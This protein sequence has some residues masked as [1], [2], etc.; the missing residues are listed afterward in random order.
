MRDEVV[1]EDVIVNFERTTLVNTREK[2]PGKGLA[3]NIY[4]H[5][6]RR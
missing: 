5:R 4:Y 6:G 3:L 1:E 2:K